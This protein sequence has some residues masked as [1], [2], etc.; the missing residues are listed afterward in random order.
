MRNSNRAC[1]W[2]D[3]EVEGGITVEG[4]IETFRAQIV[5]QLR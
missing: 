2:R 3:V 5:D 4:N 1:H